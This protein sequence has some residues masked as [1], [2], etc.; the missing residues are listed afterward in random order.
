VR[1]APFVL[2][3]V[4]APASAAGSSADQ[5]TGDRAIDRILAGMRAAIDRGLPYDAQL[6]RAATVRDVAILLATLRGQGRVP[7]VLQ[8]VGHGSPGRL[9]LA[10]D[11]QHGPSVLTSAPES[12]GMLVGRLAAP[13]RVLLLGCHV[14]SERPSAHVASGKALLFSIEVLTGAHA[15]AAD[16]PVTADDFGDGFLHDGSLVMSCGKPA[17]PGSIA[18]G[19]NVRRADAAAAAAPPATTTP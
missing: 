19:R 13:T 15:Y 8:L 14:G 10:V 9:Q 2:S 18:R 16:G 3:V 1:G 4:A 11:S 5:L 12:C 7:D 6:A 17:N